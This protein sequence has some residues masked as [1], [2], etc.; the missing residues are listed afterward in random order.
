MVRVNTP[1]MRRWTPLTAYRL[2]TPRNILSLATLLASSMA[3]L[4]S[5]TNSKGVN[6]AGIVKGI[7]FKG[8]IFCK[9][10]IEFGTIPQIFESNIK[11]IR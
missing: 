2:R 6:Q 4:E 5:S 3:V 10:S 8:K 9:T 1:L 11:H 7:V